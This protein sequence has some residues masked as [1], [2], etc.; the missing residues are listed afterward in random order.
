VRRPIILIGLP[1]AGKTTAAPHAAQLLDAP[2]CDLDQRI[3]GGTGQSIA[4]IFAG[5]GEPHFR[6]LERREMERALAEP[7]QV[8]AAGAGWA[9]QMEISPPLSVAPSPYICHSRRLRQ[10]RV[11]PEPAIVRCSR[12]A[13]RQSESPSCS[14][15]AIVGTG[16][17][18]SRL[19]WDV[20]HPMLLRQGS[21]RRLGSTEGGRALQLARNN[22]PVYLRT[23]WPRKP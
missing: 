4:E 10:P 12:E 7:P 13:R 23:R 2:W 21:S 19:T 9:A 16:W 6:D 3:V 22:P 11:L 1:G 17:R 5:R 15:R 8:I 18:I 14:R 20:R